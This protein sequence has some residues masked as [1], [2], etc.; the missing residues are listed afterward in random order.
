MA[1]TLIKDLPISVRLYYLF[2]NLNFETL[3][4]ICALSEKDLLKRRN[5][6]KK[7]VHEIKLILKEHGLSLKPDEKE[8]KASGQPTKRELFAAMFMHAHVVSNLMGDRHP[9]S[10]EI[11]KAS[12]GCAD[13][14]IKELE[15]ER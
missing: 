6:G 5:C 12:I 2:R 7:A 10:I 13:A 9:T 14:L 4:E 8:L 11:A 1:K 3:E 15:K